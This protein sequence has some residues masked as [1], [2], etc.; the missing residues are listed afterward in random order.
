VVVGLAAPIG[1]TSAAPD[2]GV[3]LYFSFEHFF[4]R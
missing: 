2:Y 4:S 3:V 1:V